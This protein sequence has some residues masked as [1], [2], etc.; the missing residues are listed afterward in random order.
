MKQG[1]ELSGNFDDEQMVH[2]NK[3]IKALSS[4]SENNQI[5]KPKF[6]VG[7]S[8]KA[9]QQF[10]REYCRLARTFL[11]SASLMPKRMP[12]ECCVGGLVA[13]PMK[14][15]VQLCGANEGDFCSLFLFFLLLIFI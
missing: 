5:N 1:R 14:L 4:I 12:K 6:K 15:R 13:T 2:R 3:T 11:L 8:E 10:Q 9:K 7:G